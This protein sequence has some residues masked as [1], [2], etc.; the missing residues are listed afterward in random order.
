MSCCSA[1]AKYRLWQDRKGNVLEAEF[2]CETAGKIVLRDPKGKEYKLSLSS[3]SQK[4][5]NYLYS[6]LPPKVEIIFSKKQDRRKHEYYADVDMQCDVTIKKK[7]RMP[8]E[9]Q[10]K[11][12]LFVIGD[13]KRNKEYV[14]LDRTE[15]EFDFKNSKEFSFK[16]AMF[17]MRQY[18]SYYY[19]SDGVEYAGFMVAVYDVDGNQVEIK[20]SRDEFINNLEKLSKFKA[21]NRFSKDMQSK[22]NIRTF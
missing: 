2:V 20:S 10:L 13:A 11:A 22:S 1:F 19:H 9:A 4:D 15:V 12:I 5:Q 17:R 18:D 8:Y 7:S 6:K 3:L 14:M 21:G 16:G